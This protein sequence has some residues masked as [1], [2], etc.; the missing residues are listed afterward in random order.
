MEYTLTSVTFV[1]V[2]Y[3]LLTVIRLESRIKRMSYKLEQV[4]QKVGVPEAPIDDDLRTLV[5][6]GKR[7]EAV[8]KAREVLGLSLTEAKQ[9]VDSLDQDK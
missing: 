2:I 8:K 4:A 7:I 5:R 1:A 9:Y 6:E 3:L